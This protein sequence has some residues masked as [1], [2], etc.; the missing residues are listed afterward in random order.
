MNHYSFEKGVSVSSPSHLL[1]SAFL[2]SLESPFIRGLFEKGIFNTLI[3][4]GNPHMTE[5]QTRDK[6]EDIGNKMLNKY[7]Y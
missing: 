7:I 4:I 3:L 2:L 5:E 6:R 1:H